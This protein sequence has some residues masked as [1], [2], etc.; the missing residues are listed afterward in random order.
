M[1]NIAFTAVQN[2]L[3]ILNLW[4]SYYGR[5]FD[6]MFVICFNTKEECFDELD[7][8]K[9]THNFDYE[10]LSEYKGDK[11]DGTP[12]V[13]IRYV[14]DKQ[15]QLIKNYDW[16]LFANC[17]EYLIPYKN[18]YKDLKD[19]MSRSKEKYVPCVAYDVIQTKKE[20]PIDYSKPYLKQRRYWIK[21]PHYNK[22][23]L[24]R[25]AL[26]WVNG[27]HKLSDMTDDDSKAIKN[28]G[29][30]MVHLKHADLSS[31]RD[32]GPYKSK[33]DPNMVANWLDKKRLIPDYIREVF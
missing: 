8:M 31:T 14:R 1:R 27:L 13:F 4:L 25:V 18:R 24:S 19:L 10:I 16:V 5:Y 29:L 15:F 12:A 7:R 21:N 30:Y 17:D 2:D 3:V 22:I 9:K 28:T 33:L 11:I 6:D 20:K 32:F 26:D 23:I